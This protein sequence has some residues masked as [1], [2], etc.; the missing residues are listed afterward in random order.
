M[1]LKFDLSR[2]SRKLYGEEL[3]N[4]LKSKLIILEPPS[5]FTTYSNKNLDEIMSFL[6]KD[7]GKLVSEF[8]Q[9]KLFSNY[10]RNGYLY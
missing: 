7:K 4:Y 1:N 6:L 10:C 5:N 3:H 8:S 2:L 9:K